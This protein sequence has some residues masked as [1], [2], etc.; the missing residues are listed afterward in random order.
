MRLPSLVVV[1]A[2]VLSVT[3]HKAFAD[4]AGHPQ[5]FGEQVVPSGQ[6]LS[7]EVLVHNEDGIAFWRALGF[8]EHTLSFQCGP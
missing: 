6:I 1:L 8:R 5:G 7:L 4:T 2:L 3:N